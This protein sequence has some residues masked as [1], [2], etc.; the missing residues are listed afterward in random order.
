MKV[1]EDINLKNEEY[2]FSYEEL[3]RFLIYAKKFAPIVPM[4]ESMTR[5]GKYIILRH[6]V[7]QDIYPSYEV[8]KIE[9]KIGVNAT[10][11]V[12]TTSYTYN[13][14][15]SK[16]RELLIEMARDGFE[17]GL[18]FDP[19]VYGNITLAEL[20][21]KVK[22]ECQILENIIDEPI[23]SISLHNPSVS[24]KYPSFK[25]YI[26]AYS[27]K[28]FSDEQYLSDAMRVDTSLHPFRGKDPYEFV[29]QAKKYPLQITLHPEQF[30]EE[31]GDYV[32]TIGRYMSRMGNDILHDYLDVLSL[33][34]RE[35]LWRIK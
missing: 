27:K 10:F 35:K 5:K 14:Q 9:K 11:F 8:S 31:G 20:Q 25:G 2:K 1:R 26:N 33:I 29:R 7:D 30:L 17:I 32:D 15:S 16:I 21:E 23:V 3:K 24:G 22:F 12:L 13:L 18:H 4:R 28:L 19:S 34:R 6:D